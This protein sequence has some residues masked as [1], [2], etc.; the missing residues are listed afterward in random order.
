METSTLILIGV[1]AIALGV[2]ATQAAISRLIRLML[3]T[4]T[5]GDASNSSSTIDSIK[6]ELQKLNEQVSLLKDKYL[7][8]GRW[9]P[10]EKV[11]VRLTEPHENRIKIIKIICDHLKLGLKE[12]M[13]LADN[14]PCIIY[15]GGKNRAE[16]LMDDLKSMGAKAEIVPTEQP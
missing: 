5:N 2:W 9:E 6:Y 10:G 15:T 16:R 7:E 8:E 4:R 3:E 12:A 14:P 13:D 11:S 1:A